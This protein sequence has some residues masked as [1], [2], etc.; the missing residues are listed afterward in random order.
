MISV[1]SNHEYKRLK[2]QSISLGCDLVELIIRYR[3]RD[4]SRL[5]IVVSADLTNRTISAYTSWVLCMGKHTIN[6]SSA[7][8]CTKML[9]S[10]TAAVKP[11]TY[12]TLFQFNQT[13]NLLFHYRTQF[14]FVGINKV[15][16]HNINIR[17]HQIKLVFHVRLPTIVTQHITDSRQPNRTVALHALPYAG[18][19]PRRTDALTDRLE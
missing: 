19:E 18:V 8:L 2:T 12:Q 6:K 9:E 11:Q 14:G 10:C 13:S 5:K 3:F 1:P 7:D 4:I 15:L 16:Y 17:S